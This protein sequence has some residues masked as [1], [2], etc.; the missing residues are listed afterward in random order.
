VD[1]GVSPSGAN[2]VQIDDFD[3][4]FSGTGQ[5][6]FDTGDDK[7]TITQATAEGTILNDDAPN[8]IPGT[9]GDDTIT[10]DGNSDG[11]I[12]NPP[13]DAPDRI[14]ALGGND[15]M[16]GGGGADVFVFSTGDGN[17]II[18]TGQ[19]GNV[20]EFEPGA[21]KIDLTNVAAITD[22]DDLVAFHQF[23]QGDVGVLI[24]TDE[25][26]TGENT[27]LLT[28]FRGEDFLD[29]TLTADDFI[30]AD[31]NSIYISDTQ[32][33]EGDSGTATDAVFTVSLSTPVAV[34]LA[35]PSRRSGCRFRGMARQSW[36]R[37]S[38]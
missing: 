9:V 12:G 28:G 11:V 10:L 27:I 36:M 34:T 4:E 35:R 30:F 26:F 32:L 7:Q 29:G 14:N 13:S 2:R 1:W 37:R 31:G 3:S 25:G 24:D 19:G 6:T 17:D 15:Q 38:S 20:A 21:D 18:G 22:F 33:T 23:Q 16:F 8:E 5:V